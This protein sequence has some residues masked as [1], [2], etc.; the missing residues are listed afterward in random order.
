M[1]EQILFKSWCILL[2]VKE[3]TVVKNTAAYTWDWHCH[4][5]GDRALL[6]YWSSKL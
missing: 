5:V 2:L 6:T 1:A 4:L 3:I